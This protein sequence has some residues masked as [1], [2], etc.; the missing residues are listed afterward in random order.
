MWSG[1]NYFRWCPVLGLTKFPNPV[2]KVSRQM[3]IGIMAN[4]TR[5]EL[6]VLKVL[7]SAPDKTEEYYGI[8]HLAKLTRRGLS[9]VLN[10][11]EAKNLVAINR[12]GRILVQITFG[13]MRA[14]AAEQVSA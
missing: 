11:M 7:D 3:E 13:G 14:L 8:R 12:N 10:R 1:G 9:I 6:L 4:I 5:S 2:Q